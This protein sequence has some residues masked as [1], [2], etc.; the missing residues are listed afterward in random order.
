[1]DL[2]SAQI[3]FR[4]PADFS[5]FKSNSDPI[6]DF[7]FQTDLN[8]FVEHESIG[9]FIVGWKLNGDGLFYYNSVF[10]I[11][12]PIHANSEKGWCYYKQKDKACGWI[13]GEFLPE[14]AFSKEEQGDRKKHKDVKEIGSVRP[15]RYCE[16]REET[17]PPS[18]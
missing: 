4:E 11:K 3:F 2:N 14:R 1:M 7:I 10:V 15:A 13:E 17:F 8:T 6:V 12:F 16:E 18:E 5:I 9:A